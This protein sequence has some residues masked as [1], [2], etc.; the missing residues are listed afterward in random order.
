MKDYY[1]ILA[2]NHSATFQEIK[3][4]FRKLSKE[5]HPDLNNGSKYSE[6]RFQ[7]IQEAYFTLKNKAKREEYNKAF[8]NA[9]RKRNSIKYKITKRLQ[10]NPFKPSFY[11]SYHPLYALLCSGFILVLIGFI[12]LDIEKNY[13]QSSNSFNMEYYNRTDTTP[14]LNLI[15]TSEEET[16]V[17]PKKVIESTKQGFPNPIKTIKSEK[18]ETKLDEELIINAVEIK[19]ISKSSALKDS[20]IILKSK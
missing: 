20:A 11:R 5:H 3:E 16:A 14:V 4:A 6:Q 15:S 8:E 7:E 18:T 1:K 10:G 13:E 2:I 17:K 9:K 12:I 19:R